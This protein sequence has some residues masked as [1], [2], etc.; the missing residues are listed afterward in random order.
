MF[1]CYSL[2]M[3]NSFHITNASTTNIDSIMN[4][5]NDSF[6]PGIQEKK[7]V[8]LERISAFPEGF[9]LLKNN[10]DNI[11][12]Y[13]CSE[14][15]NLSL[16]KN[17][18][19]TKQKKESVLL[20]K[21]F[22]N[23]SHTELELLENNSS[24]LESKPQKEISLTENKSPTENSLLKNELYISIPNE[25]YFLLGHNPT[26]LHN[27]NGN[28]LYISSIGIHSSQRGKGLGA[29]FAKEA[30]NKVLNLFPC[31]THGILIVN[32]KWLGAKKI[33]EKMGFQDKTVFTDF[34]HPENLPSENAI[35]MT[36]KF[37]DTII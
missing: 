18:L 11:I 26:T 36:S 9:F 14:I 10:Q 34:F 4:I 24:P 17:E 20:G 33:Y 27:Y 5:E 8:F 15:W 12:G 2:S 16:I 22:Q 3:I 6:L 30:V 37:R 13:F 31:I 25:D 1:S 32:E 21:N 35:L 19:K 29:F 7:S 28:T 23:K